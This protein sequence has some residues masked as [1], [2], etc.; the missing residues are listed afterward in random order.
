MSRT[1]LIHGLISGA[2]IICGIIITILIGGDAPHSNVWL[3]YLIM[4]VGL[5]AILLA[6]KQHRDKVLGGVIKFWPAFLIG[7]GVAG[8]AALAYVLIW[9]VYLA[10]TNYSFMEQY[11]ASTLAQKKAA[12]VSGGEY[13]KL[14]ADLEAIKRSYANPLYRLPM[15]FAEIF[16]VGLL[17]ALVSAALLR[18]PRFLPARA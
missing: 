18:N 3:G 12:G 15:T 11:V 2:V 16:P 6:I 7:L 14:V 8:V 13:A 10:L 17:V 4:L 5:S 1:I 9:E